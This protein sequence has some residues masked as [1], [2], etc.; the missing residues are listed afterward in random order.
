MIGQKLVIMN[1]KYPFEYNSMQP[2][3]DGE[4]NI[5]GM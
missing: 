1:H 4:D 5:N 3:F 2:M